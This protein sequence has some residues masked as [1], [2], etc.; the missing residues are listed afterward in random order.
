MRFHWRGLVGQGDVTEKTTLF[1]EN[2]RASQQGRTTVKGNISDDGVRPMLMHV[3]V[4]IHCGHPGIREEV[5]SAEVTSGTLHC[6][7]CGLDGPLNIEIR[8]SPAV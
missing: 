4:C 3:H 5:E 8:E 6:P 7:K 2:D 1:D